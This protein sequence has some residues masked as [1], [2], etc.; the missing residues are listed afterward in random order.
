M[1][2]E[3]VALATS[4]ATTLVGLLVTDGWNQARQRFTALLSQSR[5]SQQEAQ[6][7]LER[8][9]EELLTADQSGDETRIAD[10]TVEL[11]AW[12]RRALEDDP[13]LRVE[14][15]DLVTEFGGQTSNSP[16]S[17]QGN[18]FHGPTAVQG[19]GVQTNRFGA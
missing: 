17:V 16:V 3:L 19:S 6:I 9:R 18:T 4:G 15:M 2:A 11:K 8:L 1:D 5:G 10:T 7:E 12:L 14:L 13:N